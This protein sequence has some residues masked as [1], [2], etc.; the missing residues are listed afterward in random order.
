[1]AVVAD[2]AAFYGAPK[3]PNNPSARTGICGVPPSEPQLRRTC[4]VI[5]IEHSFYPAAFFAK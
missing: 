1:M 4:E 5:S 2:A 3:D